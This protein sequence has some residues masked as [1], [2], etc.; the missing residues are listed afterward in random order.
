MDISFRENIKSK[1]IK[2]QNI[3]GIWLQWEDQIYK[4]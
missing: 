4:Y 1:T 3:K 2:A